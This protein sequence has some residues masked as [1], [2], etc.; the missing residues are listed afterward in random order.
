MKRLVVVGVLLAFIFVSFK[1]QAQNYIR[2]GI[3]SKSWSC[4]LVGLAATLTECQA[5]PSQSTDRHYITDIVIQTTTATSGTFQIR[6]GTGTNCA[7]AATVLFPAIAGAFNSP[8]TAEPMA[9]INFITP[10]RPPAGDAICVIGQATN[11]TDIQI[12]G[13]L[14]R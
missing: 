13:F 7:T 8:P 4:S 6:S 3:L 1:A 10:I 12:Q 2:P 9:I 14:S 5:I 11:T